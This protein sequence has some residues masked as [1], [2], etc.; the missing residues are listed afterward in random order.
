MSYRL[1]DPPRDITNPEILADYLRELVREVEQA[2]LRLQGTIDG[3][4]P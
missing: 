3:G 4:G 1:P 2:L